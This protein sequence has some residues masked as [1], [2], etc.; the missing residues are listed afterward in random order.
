MRNILCLL[1]F[2]EWTSWSLHISVHCYDDD[3]WRHRHCRHC[4]KY[5]FKNFK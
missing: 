3:D 2:H 1:G 4:A 5:E